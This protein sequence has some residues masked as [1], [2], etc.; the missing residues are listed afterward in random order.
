VT[1]IGMP[2]TT[3]MVM[4]VAT[5]RPPSAGST[6]C[7]KGCGFFGSPST[8]NMCSKCFKETCSQTVAS[9]PKLIETSNEAHMEAEMK[10]LRARVARAEAQ[11]AMAVEKATLQERCARAEIKAAEDAKAKADAKAAADA[12]AAAQAAAIAAKLAAEARAAAD[13]RAAAA[14]RLCQPTSTRCL[15]EYRTSPPSPPSGRWVGTGRNQQNGFTYRITFY[16]D[17][18]DNDRVTGVAVPPNAFQGFTRVSF[19]GTLD[20]SDNSCKLHH[21]RQSGWTKCRF[22]KHGNEWVLHCDWNMANISGWYGTHKLEFTGD[23]N[24]QPGGFSLF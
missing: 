21:M 17:F 4:P 16:L 8:G 18:S 6:Q 10:E 15:Y 20:R 23:P 2:I 22:S 11:A 3:P 12:R 1:P 9:T 5:S 14:A 7:A 13:A 19:T 24:T